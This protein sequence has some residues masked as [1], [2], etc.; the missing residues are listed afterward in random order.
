MLRSPQRAGAHAH[1]PRLI[2]GT[3]GATGTGGPGPAHQ[4]AEK[5]THY[6]GVAIPLGFVHLHAY[7]V[8][9]AVRRHPGCRVDGAGT[10]Q[11]VRVLQWR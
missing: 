2:V 5:R 4:R 11:L 3:G 8:Q 1:W 9:G 10:G 6:V 7:V